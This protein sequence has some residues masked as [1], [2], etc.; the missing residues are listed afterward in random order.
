M[1]TQ[2]IYWSKEKSEKISVYHEFFIKALSFPASTCTPT[3]V[4]GEMYK[5]GQIFISVKQKYS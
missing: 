4:F 2:T 3:V 5:V 1:A